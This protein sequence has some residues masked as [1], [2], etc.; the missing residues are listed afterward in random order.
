MRERSSNSGPHR[1]CNGAV[2]DP[3][4]ADEA[5]AQAT[6]GSHVACVRTPSEVGPFASWLQASSAAGSDVLMLHIEADE[7]TVPPPTDVF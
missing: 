5:F 3:R 4:P 7:T 2:F 6:G 1:L